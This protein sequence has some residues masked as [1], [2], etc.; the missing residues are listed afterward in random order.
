MLK[1]MNLNEINSVPYPALKAYIS[2]KVQ[3]WIEEYELE[4]LN[5]IGCFVLLNP[6]E[7]ELFETSEM[8]FTETLK[9]KNETYLH[10][11]KMLGDCYGEDT[12]LIVEEVRK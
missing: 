4:T 2:Q 10:G 9:L 6:E 7:K 1:I 11:V 12:F 8:E 3:N 5:E